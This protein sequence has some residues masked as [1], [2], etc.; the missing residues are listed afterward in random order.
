MGKQ[1]WKDVAE[2]HALTDKGQDNV[3]LKR[4]DYESRL[5]DLHVKLVQL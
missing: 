1:T 2:R 5:R 3:R 4:K